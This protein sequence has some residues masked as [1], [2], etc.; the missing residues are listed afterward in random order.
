VFRKICDHF[1]E[2]L[3]AVILAV[4]VSV[5]FVN[6]VTRYAIIYPLAWTEEITVSMFVW[7]V[8][9]GVSTA[10][11]KN[12]HLSMTFVYDFMPLPLKKI[13]FLISNAM[14]LV[15][16]ALLT[17]LG[18][19]QVLDEMD[20]GVTSEALAIPTAIYSA[21]IPV[22]SVL[23]IVRILQSCRGIIRDSRY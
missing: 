11:R 9:L 23:I 13:S 17:W 8:L 19:V 2:I 22:F 20:L 6:V 15:F 3:G 14:S 1:E 10:F 5:A 12:A 18:T 21:G 16:F 7:I 4:M